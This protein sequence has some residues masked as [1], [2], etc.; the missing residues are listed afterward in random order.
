[1]DRR[2]AIILLALGC[3]I[4]GFLGVCTRHFFALGLNS[5]DISFIR[6][7]L[8]AAALFV[9]IILTDRKVLSVDRKDI[10]FLVAFGA[11]KL[12]SDI[13]LFKAQENTTLALS[14]LL[15]MTFPYYT[16]ILS[17]FIF[18]EKITSRKLVAMFVAFL[19]CMLVTGGFFDMDNSNT[20]G[21]LCALFSGLCFG[22][23]IIG[24]SIYV[25]K[26][27]NP[28]TFVFY[29][30]LVS[31]LIDLPFVDLG[32][33][34]S[35]VAT[36]DSIG[37]A[38]VFGLGLTLIPMFLMA[39]SARYIE[40]TTISVINMVEIVAAALVGF[41]FFGESLS[42]SNILGMILVMSSVVILN[43]RIKKGAEK[44]MKEHGIKNP[45]QIESKT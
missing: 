28:E 22:L 13:A 23:Y 4:F 8:T 45:R 24:N 20:L 37:Y 27:K 25:G 21:I 7:S 44:Y 16:L 34:V 36:L 42:A 19:G 41:V 31:A 6:Q 11:V 29:C 30:F 15:Q 32:H 2:Q 5:F 40:A 1:M 17:L 9:I 26:G 18:H 38:L 10:L 43:I 35:V 39:V 14:A 33:T 12:L 3:S